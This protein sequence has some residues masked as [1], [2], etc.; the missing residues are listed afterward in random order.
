MTE[1]HVNVK[2]SSTLVLVSVTKWAVQALHSFEMNEFCE[3][4]S[5]SFSL[6]FVECASFIQSASVAEKRSK[7]VLAVVKKSEQLD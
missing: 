4:F 2:N 6:C 1:L 7:N 5:H 3:I